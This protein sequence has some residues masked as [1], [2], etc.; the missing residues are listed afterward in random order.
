MKY[1]GSIGG[2]HPEIF[3]QRREKEMRKLTVLLVLGV[4]LGLAG[5]M[6]AQ[7]D[8]GD[9]ATIVCAD[10][11]TVIFNVETTAAAGL[12][13]TCTATSSCMT[14]LKDL[15]DDGWEFDK[16]INSPIPVLG[17]L[18]AGTTTNATNRVQYTLEK[19]NDEPGQSGNAPGRSRRR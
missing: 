1:K 13:A 5:W 2:P 4:F 18:I 10:V 19:D 3:M 15:F 16:D 9:I 8:Q 17:D 14:C 12:P 6:P 7:A 11:P